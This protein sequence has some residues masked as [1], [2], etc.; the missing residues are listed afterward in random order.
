MNTCSTPTNDNDIEGIRDYLSW[1]MQNEGM[2]STSLHYLEV[3]YL[4]IQQL[5]KKRCSGSALAG[6]ALSCRKANNDEWMEGLATYINEYA[7]S[8]ND[9]DRFEFNGDGLSGVRDG[10]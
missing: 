2:S 6:Y 4:K 1:L 8:I 9:S 3:L 7:E 5:Q 10:G